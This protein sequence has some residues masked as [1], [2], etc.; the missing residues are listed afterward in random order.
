MKK[1]DSSETLSHMNINFS[2]LHVSK[3]VSFSFGI[4]WSRGTLIITRKTTMVI[5]GRLKHL[6]CDSETR[7][8]IGKKINE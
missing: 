5:T 3:S 1:L 6:V 8:D 7:I 4:N 2:L